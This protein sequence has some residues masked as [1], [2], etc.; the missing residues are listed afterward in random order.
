VLGAARA[1]TGIVGAGFI[2][3]PNQRI[4]LETQGQAIDPGVL[5]QVEVARRDG[6]SVRLA[7]VARV[8]EAGAPRFG[9]A[10]IQGRPGVL[11]TMLSQY[12]ANT[13][14]VTQAVEQALGGIRPG[15]DQQ[16]G[17]LYSRPAPPAPFIRP[18]L[19]KPPGSR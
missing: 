2:D 12:G 19:S 8:V 3:P 4:V 9:E 1:S 6:L 15:L 16:G 17:T 11:L 5:A 13:M 14:E 18:A 7:D 10:L